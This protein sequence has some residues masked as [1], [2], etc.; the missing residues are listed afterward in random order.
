MDDCLPKTLNMNMMRRMEMFL[1]L[2][3][4][5]L[6][7]RTRLCRPFARSHNETS[8][9]STSPIWSSPSSIEGSKAVGVFTNVSGIAK[10]ARVATIM[11]AQEIINGTQGS[12]SAIAAPAGVPNKS[13]RS[14][15]AII[16]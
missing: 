12:T 9:L 5:R 10:A 13:D 7:S 1:L 4:K 2:E 16:A 14:A 15:K 6:E 3:M 8:S 11:T